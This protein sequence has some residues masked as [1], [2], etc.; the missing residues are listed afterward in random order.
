MGQQLICIVAAQRS[1]TTALREYMAATGRIWNCGEIFQTNETESRSN[2]FAF[3][4]Q[5]NVQVGDFRLPKDVHS[6]ADR[7][8]A[9]LNALAGTKHT[10]IDVKFN[11][12]LFLSPAW[13]Y[14]HDEP[15]LLGFLKKRGCHFIFLQRQD[16]AQQIASEVIARSTEKWHNLTE[17]D[18]DGARIEADLQNV[19]HQANQICQSEVFFWNCLRGSE[20]AHFLTYES[21]FE[22]GNLARAVQDMLSEMVGETLTFPSAAKIQKNPDTKS[23][24]LVN[25][26]ELTDVV[27][28]VAAQ[29]RRPRAVTAKGLNERS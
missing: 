19:R 15:F 18:L 22:N 2:F 20:R 4:R 3:C 5:A 24:S 11:S 1:G 21:L 28:E 6:L 26:G 7:F 23:T 9:E 29:Y 8:F 13:R 14:P 17:G 27:A 10:L 25:Y 16:L 12:W